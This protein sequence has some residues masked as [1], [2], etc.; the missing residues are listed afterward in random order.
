MSRTIYFDSNDLKKNNDSVEGN[1]A[2]VKNS[3]VRVEIKER[4]QGVLVYLGRNMCKYKDLDESTA[5]CRA[6]QKVLIMNG[7][8]CKMAA[9]SSKISYVLDTEDFFI[10][11]GR[12]KHRSPERSSHKAQARVEQFHQYLAASVV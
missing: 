7:L 11:L 6:T 4:V 2:A 5:L 3:K 8:E 9:T 12:R 1:R 10:R